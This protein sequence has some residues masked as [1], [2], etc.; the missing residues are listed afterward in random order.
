MSGQLIKFIPRND[1]EAG[2]NVEAFVAMCRDQLTA[3]GPGLEFS[4]NCWD[5]TD[6][7]E[8]RGR[9]RNTLTFSACDSR[10][11]NS[12][13]NQ[14]MQEP[15]LSFAKAYIR[16]SYSI[17]P[18]KK[19]DGHIYALRTLEC[20]LRK[21]NNEPAI[22]DANADTF[23]IAANITLEKYSGDAYKIGRNLEI[24]AKFCTEHQL[25]ARPVQWKSHIPKNK[26]FGRLGNEGE[27]YRNSKLPTEAALNAIPQIFRMAKTPAD[28]MASS[29]LALLCCTNCRISELLTLPADCEVE[30]KHNGKVVYGLRWRPAKGAPPEI[31][32]VIPTMV[33][34]AKEAIKRIRSLT[35]EARR[36]AR[37]YEKNTKQLYLPFEIEH[38]RFQTLLKRD[39]VCSITGK[40]KGSLPKFYRSHNII[41][42]RGA[43]RFSEFEKATISELPRYFPYLWR[44]GGLKF[45]K[46][47]FVIRPNELNLCHGMNKSLCEQFTA[48]SIYEEFGAHEKR[49]DLSL[50]SRFGFTEPDGSPIKITSHQFRHWQNTMA[51]RGGLS[52]LDIA[53]WSGRA[54]IHQNQ[55][56][57]HMT[58]VE[59]LQLLRNIAG[60]NLNLANLPVAVHRHDPV[61]W[62][63]FI[64]MKIPAA[65]TT[66]LGFCVHDF[67]FLPCQ[68]HHDCLFCTEHCYIKGDQKRMNYARQALLAAEVQLQH[69]EKALAENES[70][71]DRWTEH[72]RTHVARLRDLV[73][74]YDDSECPNGSLIWLSNS[75]LP[76]KIRFAIE[77]R[78]RLEGPRWNIL[79]P[80]SSQ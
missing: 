67:V 38:L 57:D 35:E 12:T 32:W 15:F 6:F 68:L 65:H 2:K 47:L 74:I 20:A 42:V 34:V 5:I 8:L 73:A 56:Y 39:E 3:F 49:G 25:T 55:D 13:Q 11:I 26:N 9:G 79:P 52:Q 7:S 4:S 80:A 16:Y 31:K 76:S 29:V 46:A 78:E 75:E 10:S 1:L 61:A 22:Q 60:E 51:Q 27:Q 17:K 66:E 69:A 77:E 21:I 50:F 63:E 28:I 53:K 24:L 54:N 37:W 30:Q 48:T 18:L 41:P 40:H 14:Y 70:G 62:E 59:K 23:T 64:E 36:I 43:V 33:E 71:A 19:M 72:Q 45:S 58:M 44:E